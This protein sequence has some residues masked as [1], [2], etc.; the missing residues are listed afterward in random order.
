[1]VSQ[2][3]QGMGAREN[4]AISLSPE[5]WGMRPGAKLRRCR[6][7]RKRIGFSGLEFGV[8]AVLGALVSQERS[9]TRKILEDK[10]NWE[11]QGMTRSRTFSGC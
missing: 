1:M 5:V 3:V 4:P 11:G 7:T 8:G 9:R 10:G 6:S 2:R